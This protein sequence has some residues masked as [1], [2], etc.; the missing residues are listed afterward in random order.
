[1]SGRTPYLKT[2]YA[3]SLQLDDI[4]PVHECDGKHFM[5]S[6]FK[7]RHRATS[8]VAWLNNGGS[9]PHDWIQTHKGKQH[10]RYEVFFKLCLILVHPL[11]E[12]ESNYEMVSLIF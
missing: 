5:H 2:F 4:H 6:L 1:M 11:K 9:H 3:P 8:I 10:I 7:K 12:T